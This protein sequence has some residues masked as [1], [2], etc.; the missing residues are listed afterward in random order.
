MSKEKQKGTSFESSLVPFLRAVWSNA[1]RL[2]AA[3]VKDK[4]D[5]GG[6]GMPFNLECKN[7]SNYG[8]K[9]AGWL[10]ETKREEVHAEKPVFLCHKRRGT[11]NPRKQFVTMELGDLIDWTISATH[12]S[13]APRL[14]AN[15][16]T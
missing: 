4:G 12:Q 2:P 13:E 6:Y 15:P 3:G 8:G 9:L 16:P 5:I 10:D 7:Y 11:T 14:K 1:D